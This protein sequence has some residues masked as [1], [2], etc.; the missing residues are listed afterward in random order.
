MINLDWMTRTQRDSV[1]K[2]ELHGL[3]VTAAETPAPPL[4]P[5]FVGYLHRAIEEGQISVRKVCELLDTTIEQLRDII[6]AH[7]LPSPFDL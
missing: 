6:E 4:S 1:S 2:E 3:E 5:V 7:Q